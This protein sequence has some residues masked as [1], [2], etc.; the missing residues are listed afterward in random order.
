MR[1]KGKRV[2][3]V[4]GRAPCDLLDVPSGE[5]ILQVER[6]PENRR[7]F[8]KIQTLSHQYTFPVMG[9]RQRYATMSAVDE[10]GHIAFRYREEPGFSLNKLLHRDLEIVISPDQDVSLELGC[11]LAVTRAFMWFYFNHHYPH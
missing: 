2:S 7:V 9:E 11:L 10:E 8:G 1:R 6:L 4:P 5:R 3:F